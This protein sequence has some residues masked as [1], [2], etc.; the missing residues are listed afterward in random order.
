MT[1]MEPGIES[2]GSPQAS[3]RFWSGNQVS[4]ASNLLFFYQIT[5]F[6]CRGPADATIAPH[7][8]LI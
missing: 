1:Q 8:F 2:L 4:K 3:H 7:V 6:H 5:F